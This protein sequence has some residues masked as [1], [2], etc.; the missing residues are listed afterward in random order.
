MNERAGKAE[1]AALD[2]NL[3]MNVERVPV[4]LVPEIEALNAGT[5]EKPKSDE[6]NYDEGANKYDAVHSLPGPAR[7]TFLWMIATFLKP[8]G[9]INK[10]NEMLFL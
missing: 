3:A 7:S 9:K 1:T 10:L 8:G 5:P 4:V 2:L 6:K